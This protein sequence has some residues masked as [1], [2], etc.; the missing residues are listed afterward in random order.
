MF[1]LSTG[2]QTHPSIPGDLILAAMLPFSV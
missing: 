1:H 2:K